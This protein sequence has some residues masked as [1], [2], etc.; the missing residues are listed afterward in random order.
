MF[1]IYRSWDSRAILRVFQAEIMRLC[2]GFQNE[3]EGWELVKGLRGQRCARHRENQGLTGFINC[4]QLTDLPLSRIGVRLHSRL[5]EPLILM[6][7]VRG[8]KQREKSRSGFRK[9]RIDNSP[10]MRLSRPKSQLTSQ[11]RG[12]N[13]LQYPSP[14]GS[15]ENVVRFAIQESKLASG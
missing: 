13:A 6:H 10:N 8:K 2:L 7:S 5:H 12:G 11:E 14:G 9:G 3:G 1:T 4:L 15:E